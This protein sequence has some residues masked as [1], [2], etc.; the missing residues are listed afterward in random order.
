MFTGRCENEQ[1]KI[2]ERALPAKALEWKSF[3]ISNLWLSLE[4]FVSIIC[5]Y[6]IY[7]V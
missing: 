7:N 3:V 2:H 5:N 6:V 1:V 4:R